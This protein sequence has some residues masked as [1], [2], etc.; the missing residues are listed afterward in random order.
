LSFNKTAV[1]KKGQAINDPSQQI[2]EYAFGDFGPNLSAKTPPEIL[3]DKPA[4]T[5]HIA[6]KRPNYAL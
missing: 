6:Y 4:V 5:T 3:D 2:L 1:T